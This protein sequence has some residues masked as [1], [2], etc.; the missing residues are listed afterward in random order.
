MN[1]YNHQQANL[2]PGLPPRGI[3]QAYRNY[4]LTQDFQ[5]L[6][7]QY[8]EFSLAL[9]YAEQEL[10][11][12]GDHIP[13]HC[14]PANNANIAVWTYDNWSWDET[15]G[16][17]AY[18]A[19]LWLSSLGAAARTAQILQ[20]QDDRERYE[21]WLEEGQRVFEEKLW[22]RGPGGGYYKLGENV[23]DVFSDYLY[24]FYDAYNGTGV[25]KPNRMRQTLRRV[26][27]DNVQDF[28]NGYYGAINGT[29]DGEV[30]EGEQERE[31]W[32]GNSFALG[33][34]MIAYGLE[35]EGWNTIY[36]T[37]NYTTNQANTFGDWAE[38]Y[39][40]E[41]GIDG[42]TPMY[43]FRAKNYL[44]VLSIWNALAIL[45]QQREND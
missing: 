16:I 11:L 17:N 28:A 4:E 18:T 33:A 9:D 19:G 32:A 13:D 2:W 41:P 31:M 34:T 45:E 5:T 26:Y 42:I 30:I 29:R 8:T 6:R 35:E 37:I 44:R 24:A 15:Q 23:E 27:R 36:G 3:L 20:I 38:A 21:S 14:I 22:R 10:D 1:T 39:T 12:D 40:L 7:D 43:G 25:F